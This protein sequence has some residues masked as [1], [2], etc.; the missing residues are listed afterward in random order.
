VPGIG[1]GAYIDGNEIHILKS[2]RYAVLRVDLYPAV[3]GVV[4]D[5]M[6][7]R[8]GRSLSRQF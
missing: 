7:I 4:T 1:N 6:L 2:T 3:P 8:L 5:A